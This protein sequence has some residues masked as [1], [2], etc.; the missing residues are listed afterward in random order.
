M[1]NHG[2]ALD[3]VVSAYQDNLFV[4]NLNGKLKTHIFVEFYGSGP[5]QEDHLYTLLF[6]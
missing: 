1:E 4:F 6:K 2:E 3:V 5:T